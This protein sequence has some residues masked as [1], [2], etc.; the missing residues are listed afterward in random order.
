MD[1]LEILNRIINKGGIMG[2][3]A[4]TYIN[5]QEETEQFIKECYQQ[6][7]NNSAQKLWGEELVHDIK[8]YSERKNTQKEVTLATLEKLPR[9]KTYRYYGLIFQ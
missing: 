4:K 8:N 2:A 9:C 1:G 7:H 5:D 3:V 6:C